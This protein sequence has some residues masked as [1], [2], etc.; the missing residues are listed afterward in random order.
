MAV[1]N[2]SYGDWRFFLAVSTIE[3]SWANRCEPADDL[4][5]PLTLNFILKTLNALSEALLSGGN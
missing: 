5:K 2:T 1:G 4:K 3:C